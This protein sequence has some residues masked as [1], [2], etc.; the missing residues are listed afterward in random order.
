MKSNIKIKRAKNGEAKVHTDYILT[1]CLLVRW[2]DTHKIIYYF[3]EILQSKKITQQLKPGALN[4][5]YLTY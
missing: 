1:R 5:E 4:G 2:R 3:L